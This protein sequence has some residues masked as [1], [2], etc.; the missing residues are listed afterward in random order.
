MLVTLGEC[1]PFLDDVNDLDRFLALCK[2][3][4]FF[5]FVFLEWDFLGKHI[6]M[7]NF[8]N[9][10]TYFPLRANTSEWAMMGFNSSEAF[11]HAFNIAHIEA[12]KHCWAFCRNLNPLFCT[13]GSVGSI[14]LC[15]LLE[16]QLKVQFSSLGYLLINCSSFDFGG[17]PL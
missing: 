15:L 9:C 8:V 5:P 16:I 10:F 2:V 11:S 1:L 4:N 7:A 13:F 3:E 14:K 6:C 17:L 12:I